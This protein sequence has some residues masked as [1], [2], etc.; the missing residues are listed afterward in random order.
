M[1]TD[2]QAEWAKEWNE[3]LEPYGFV[4][5][6]NESGWW[7]MPEAMVDRILA[8]RHLAQVAAGLADVLW[9]TPEFINGTAEER[10][11]WL[12]DHDDALRTWE[13][14]QHNDG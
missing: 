3:S 14:A 2:S 13:E 4:E 11:R 10:Q 6:H 5:L 8:D 12:A 7:A 9:R 1:E